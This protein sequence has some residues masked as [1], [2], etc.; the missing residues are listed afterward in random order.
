MRPP[1]LRRPKEV[2]VSHAH[3]DRAFAAKLTK[4]L[5]QHGIMYWYSPKHIVGAQQ[6]HDEIGKALARCDWFVVVLSPRAVKSKWVAHEYFYALQEDRYANRILPLLYKKCD[7]KA[8]SWT[9]K[10]FQ[11][12]DF[13]QDYQKACRELLKTW[14]LGA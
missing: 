11:W 1:R 2:F 6:W 8:L 12:V 5:Q 4:T 9:L 14:G 7:W 3:Q 13:R 10:R